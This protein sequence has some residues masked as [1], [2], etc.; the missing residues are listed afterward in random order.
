MQ[1]GKKPSPLESTFKKRIIRRLKSI[2]KL[3]YFCKEAKAIVGIPDIIICY[4]GYFF[5][6]EVKRCVSEVYNKDMQMK[7][8]GRHLR[9]EL[10]MNKMRL[11][12]GK[13]AFIYPEN[14]EEIFEWMLSA[15]SNEQ[16]PPK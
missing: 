13:A 3:Y 16:H 14:E 10:E 6:L 1:V 15:S 7:D 8:S 9:Q 11:A 12:E 5:A 2:P 4:R